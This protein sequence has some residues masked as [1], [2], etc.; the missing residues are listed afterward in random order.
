MSKCKQAACAEDILTTNETRKSSKCLLTQRLPI[1][2]R[3][4]ALI[5]TFDTTE[6]LQLYYKK[7]KDLNYKKKVKLEQLQETIQFLSS[8]PSENPAT[9]RLLTQNSSEKLLNSITT[10][11]QNTENEL[12]TN[13]QLQN[14]RKRELITNEKLQEDNLKSRQLYIQICAEYDKLKNMTS[15]VDNLKISAQSALAKYE[16]ISKNE[17]KAM[18]RKLKKKK[19][20]VFEWSEKVK[21]I[22]AKSEEK[23]R[24]SD[25][26]MQ[27]TLT[28]KKE[29]EKKCYENKK[30][31]SKNV[32]DILKNYKDKFG[33]VFEKLNLDNA[34]TKES[35]DSIIKTLNMYMF[36]DGSLSE[37]YFQLSQ[38]HIR[39][40]EE[41]NKAIKEI[42]NITDIDRK[43]NIG[44]TLPLTYNMQR[45]QH[46]KMIKE[47]TI[48]K[49]LLKTYSETFAMGHRI[50]KLISNIKNVSSMPSR[51]YSSYKKLQNIL[52]N[53]K[54]KGRKTLLKA[55]TQASLTSEP[56][57]NTMKSKLNIAEEYLKHYPKDFSTALAIQSIVKSSPVLSFI[58]NTKIF[59]QF[60]IISDPLQDLALLIEDCYN[61]FSGQYRL[62]IETLIDILQE[63]R[64]FKA[65]DPTC[66]E[67]EIF[68]IR[69]R[70]I[71]L[72]SCL[73]LGSSGLNTSRGGKKSQKSR[74]EDQIKLSSIKSIREKLENLR[75]YHFRAAKTVDV[76]H[77]NQ[78][79]TSKSQKSIK[80]TKF[81]KHLVDD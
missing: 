52:V 1:K 17:A 44:V 38:C 73:T 79:V 8:I 51:I 65:D 66:C 2:K 77:K 4:S 3:K 59:Q 42:S 19:S 18:K 76:F 67:N 69:R 31:P 33:L 75:K 23:I 61:S 71:Q 35:I 57:E 6:S 80:L 9:K 54:K 5:G 72:K 48:E 55:L 14:M 37:R 81:G 29:L 62:L 46:D 25:E 50:L 20:E 10:C 30:S 63:T 24:R 70:A 64:N 21:G 68:P 43:P 32:K 7:L 45:T 56:S 22:R 74:R 58:I 27:K 34:L 47:E 39:K 15:N 26:K 16:K 13:S 49:L 28:L 11:E 40:I 78:L 36:R 60:L 53:N 12:I 41:F